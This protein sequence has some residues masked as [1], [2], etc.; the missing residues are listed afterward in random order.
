MDP[1][2]IVFLTAAF[3]AIMALLRF[4]LMRPED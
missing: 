1:L 4:K 2:V 3:A